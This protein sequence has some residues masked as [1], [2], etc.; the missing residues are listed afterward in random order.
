VEIQD[1]IQ[2]NLEK[3]MKRFVLFLFFL[4]FISSVNAIILTPSLINL[5]FVANEQQEIVV[6]IIEDYP[7]TMKLELDFSRLNSEVFPQLEN[8]ITLDKTELIFT[9]N[10]LIQEYTISIAFPTT[11]TSGLHELRVS[12]TEFGNEEE[13]NST[14]YALASVSTRLLI[15]NREENQENL[16]EEGEEVEGSN[17]DN[18][19]EQPNGPEEFNASELENNN[20][21]GSHI[22]EPSIISKY[23]LTTNIILVV[24]VILLI[25]IIMILVMKLRKNEEELNYEEE[26]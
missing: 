22:E 9:E 21:A 5:D 25:L 6:E 23:L 2:Y 8:S 19:D 4:F 3:R 1:L 16:S 18:R 15:H 12:A 13:Q 26:I 17:G 14:T 24:G 7:T 10:S 11:L 20:G